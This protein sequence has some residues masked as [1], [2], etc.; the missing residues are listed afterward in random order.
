M[1]FCWNDFNLCLD[2]WWSAESFPKEYGR[3]HKKNGLGK[4]LK[5][6]SRP[7]R[8]QYNRFIDGRF[9]IINRLRLTRAR[10]TRLTNFRW[11]ILQFAYSHETLINKMEGY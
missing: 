5:I 1:W 7:Y 9:P 6:S 11:A 10:L 8:Q 2:W 3:I 4:L